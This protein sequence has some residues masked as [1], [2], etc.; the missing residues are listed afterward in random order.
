MFKGGLGFG[1]ATRIG[2]GG[3]KVTPTIRE[4]GIVSGNRL[5]AA[6]GAIRIAPPKAAI[7]E[8]GRTLGGCPNSPPTFS[9]DSERKASM[10]RST[11]TANGTE[12]PAMMEDESGMEAA[13][14]PSAI[15]A[16]PDD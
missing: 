11:L 16:T 6:D 7:R 12:R 8:V 9:R 2:Q 14:P 10:A 3:A 4:R 1:V 5:E 15:L 13:R